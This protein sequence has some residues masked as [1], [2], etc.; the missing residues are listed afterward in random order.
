M[1]TP[2]FELETGKRTSTQFHT[3]GGKHEREVIGTACQPRG[4]SRGWFG[5]RSAFPFISWIAC[6]ILVLE[7]RRKTFY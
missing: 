4:S 6:R 7:V 3:V 1:P 5:L 2:N